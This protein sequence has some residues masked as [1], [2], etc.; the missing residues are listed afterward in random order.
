MMS[1]INDATARAGMAPA[2]RDAFAAPIEG[3]AAQLRLLTAHLAA[4][5]ARLEANSVTFVHDSAPLYQ[6]SS[7][8]ELIENTFQIVGR[9]AFDIRIEN[10]NLFHVKISCYIQPFKYIITTYSIES[11]NR[12]HITT[13]LHEVSKVLLM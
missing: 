7:L 13:L 11:F 10:R 9:I 3:A 1:S 5:Q 2:E 12:I 6:Q 8:G 4:L